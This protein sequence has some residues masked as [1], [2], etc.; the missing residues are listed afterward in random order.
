MKT[1]II[2]TILIYVL[3]IACGQTATMPEPAIVES[4]IPVTEAPP[5]SLAEPVSSPTPPAVMVVTV[6]PAGTLPPL[7]PLTRDPNATLSDTGPWLLVQLEFGLWAIDADGTGFVEILNLDLRRPTEY[8]FNLSAAPRGGLAAFLQIDDYYSYSP[9]RLQLLSLPDGQIQQLAVLLPEGI[10]YDYDQVSSDEY[11][12]AIQR[13]GSVGMRNRLSWSS[14]GRA[15]AFVGAMDGPSSDLYVYSVANDDITRLTTG[16]TQAVVFDWSPD[17]R[18]ILNGGVTHLGIETSGDGFDWVNMWAASADDSGVNLVYETDLYGYEYLMDWISDSIYLGDEYTWWEAYHGLKLVDI[19]A[20]EVQ[21]LDWCGNYSSRDF[22]PQ[23]GMLLLAVPE[24]QFRECNPDPEPGLY[25]LSINGGPAER[26]LDLLPQYWNEVEWAP[27]L[28]VFLLL[29]EDGIVTIEPSGVMWMLPAPANYI[30]FER[31]EAN[32]P[33]FAPDGQRWAFNQ[34]GVWIGAPDMEL[35]RI[36][37]GD[38]DKLTWSPDG[39]TLFFFNDDGIY[40]AFAPDFRPQ[41]AAASMAPFVARSTPV[42]VER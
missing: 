17:D 13:W 4:A 19:A 29:T 10:N 9:P 35:R 2:N 1:R 27:E 5:T 6:E 3:L 31:Y 18:Y 30:S 21:P 25:L 33:V 39:Q 20:G 37:E 42:W 36:Y 24:E 34:E 38:V 40:L 11:D 8:M 15:L 26:I 28:G 12:F 16:P 32:L 41:L 7:P 23:S 22:D 14:D